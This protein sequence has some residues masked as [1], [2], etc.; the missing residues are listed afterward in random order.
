[1]NWNSRSALI[2]MVVGAALVGLLWGVGSLL[3]ALGLGH[4]DTLW[5]LGLV[6]LFFL[7]GGYV[8][9]WRAP[10][11]FMGASLGAF[12]GWALPAQFVGG[13]TAKAIDLGLAFVVAGLVAIGELG[14]L[15]M[16]LRA[17]KRGRA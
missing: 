16:R 4:P 17:A 5:P 15:G 10:R 2:N 11:G 9:A 8:V 1:M 3:S 7:I 13:P 14:A 12:F 6:L